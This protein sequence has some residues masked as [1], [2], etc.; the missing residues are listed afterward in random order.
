MERKE[1][2]EREFLEFRLHHRHSI[3]LDHHQFVYKCS[4][5]QS[6]KHKISHTNMYFLKAEETHWV[7]DTLEWLSGLVRV[8]YIKVCPQS[9]EYLQA[10][11]NSCKTENKD[12]DKQPSN[13][14]SLNEC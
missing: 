11:N 14:I 7:F 3:V 13:T 10:V 4:W 12:E 5:F 9:P 8:E 2:L 1:D 6:K